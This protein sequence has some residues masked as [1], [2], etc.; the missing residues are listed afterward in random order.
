MPQP[1]HLA[2][3]VVSGDRHE[4]RGRGGGGK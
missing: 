1:A 4:K 2:V 3:D